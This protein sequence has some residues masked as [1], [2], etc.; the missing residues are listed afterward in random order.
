MFFRPSPC[1]GQGSAKSDKIQDC[2]HGA[3]W[4]S[5]AWL[6][7]EKG[8]RQFQER[9]WWVMVWAVKGGCENLARRVSQEAGSLCRIWD[10]KRTFGGWH[11]ALISCVTLSRSPCILGLRAPS[12]EKLRQAVLT[13]PPGQ[14]KWGQ[15]NV[16]GELPPLPRGSTDVLFPG[17]YD[18]P[19]LWWFLTLMHGTV[20]GSTPTC[21][22]RQP[23]C[24]DWVDLEHVGL[25][26]WN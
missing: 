23:F 1:A 18:T 25:W 2:L 8:Q 26:E 19:L 16:T 12:S 14:M 11:A 22:Q 21:T 24:R 17:L 7:L 10:R 9:G 20:K 5:G 13:Q 6:E 4:H 3:Q 15:N